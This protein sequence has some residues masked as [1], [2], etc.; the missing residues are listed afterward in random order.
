MCIP[1]L[2]AVFGMVGSVVS[3]MGSA[4]AANAQAEQASYNA[5]VERANANAA[6]RDSVIKGDRVQSKYDTEM[7]K[8]RAGFAKAGVLPSA[9]SALRIWEESAD[10]QFLDVATTEHNEITKA[11]AH[12]NKAGDF[13]M[14]AKAHRQAASTSFLT[15]IVGGLGGL[16]KGGGAG[17]ALSLG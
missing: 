1:I 16:A 8:Q 10:N 13:E 15:G 5:A 6:F 2:G 17:S 3:A 11:N 9:G 14:Q 4:Q 12:N 7:G